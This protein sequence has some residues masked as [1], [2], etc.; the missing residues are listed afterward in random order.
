MD[1]TCTGPTILDTI[2]LLIACRPGCQ[3]CLTQ[4][5]EVPC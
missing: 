2:G 3:T 4:A 5:Q 1:D